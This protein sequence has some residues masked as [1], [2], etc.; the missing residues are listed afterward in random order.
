MCN[1]A[2]AKWRTTSVT[3][4]KKLDPFMTD[5]RPVMS[6]L[7]H[8]IVILDLPKLNTNSRQK[9]SGRSFRSHQFSLKSLSRSNLG[10]IQ[11]TILDFSRHILVHTGNNK[12]FDG[13]SHIFPRP[14]K[15]TQSLLLRSR[16]K[17]FIEI[18]R[19]ED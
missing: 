5:R 18:E 15:F 19:Y 14:H 1:S 11:L 10:Q 4:Q 8:T 9:Q 2:R 3:S 12:K 16:G 13:L 7:L 17:I 6:Q